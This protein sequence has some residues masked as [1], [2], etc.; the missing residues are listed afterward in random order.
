MGYMNHITWVVVSDS[1]HAKVYSTIK[2]R[3][4]A[5]KPSDKSL[6]LI[7]ELIHPEAKLRDQDLVSDKQGQFFNA[8][9]SEPTDPKRHENEKFA[10]EISK[11]LTIGRNENSFHD[12]ILIS[13]PALMGMLK[14]QLTDHVKQMVSITIEKDYIHQDIKKLIKHLQEHL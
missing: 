7:H 9:F 4:F 10:L 2:A 8:T 6:T 13:P 14:K 12:L 1:C 5:E 3:L 11:L